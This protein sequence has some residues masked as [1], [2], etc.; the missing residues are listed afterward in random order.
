MEKSKGLQH[1]HNIYAQIF[2]ETGLG[3]LV[4]IS[5]LTSA[6]LCKAWRSSSNDAQGFSWPL[7][8]YLLLMSL[9]LTFW[10]VMMINQVLVGYCLAALTATDPDRDAAGEAT[11]AT[12]QP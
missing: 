1:A 7:A 12:Q 3:G 8:L 11:P 5:S 4:L 9:G 10:Q 6:A 2:A